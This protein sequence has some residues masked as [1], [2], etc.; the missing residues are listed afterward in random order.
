MYIHSFDRY[1]DQSTTLHALGLV[2]LHLH[3]IYAIRG[4]DGV[5]R[6]PESIKLR[7][8]QERHVDEDE[9]VSI[10]CVLVACYWKEKLLDW[11]DLNPS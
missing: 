1:I 4:V 11:T 5:D 6:N 3:S 8:W 7:R 9:Q 10:V 2:D